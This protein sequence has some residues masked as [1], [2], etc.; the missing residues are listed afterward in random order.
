MK[1][2]IDTKDDSPADIRKVISLLSKLI[3]GNESHSNIFEDPSPDLNT[4]SSSSE[5]NASNAFANMFGNDNSNSLES[6]KQEE[7]EELEEKEEPAEIM[8]Y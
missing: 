6:E 2:T 7:P 4:G 1:I 5:A 8:P 3:E